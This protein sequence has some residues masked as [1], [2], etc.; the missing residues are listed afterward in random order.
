MEHVDIQPGEI[1][2]PH[3]WEFADATEREAAVITDATLIGRFALQLSP[4]TLWRLAGVSPASWDPLQADPTSSAD[5]SG[6][7]DKTG[8]DHVAGVMTMDLS[9]NETTRTVTITPTGASFDVYIAGV[10]HTKTGPQ[11]IQHGAEYGKHFVF[12]DE[13]GTLVTRQTAWDLRAH[14]PVFVAFWDDSSSDALPFYELH[15]SDRG[16]EWHVNAHNTIGTLASRTGFTASGYTLNDGST[17]AAVTLSIGSGKLRDEDIEVITETLAD[18]GPYLILERS[19]ASGLWRTSHSSVLPFL[20]T[21]NTL[22]YNQLNGGVWGRGAVTEDYYVN[23]FAVGLTCLP[24]DKITPAHPGSLQFAFFPGQ[25]EYSTQEAAFAESFSALSWGDMPIE[26][27]APLYQITIRRNATAPTAYTNTARCAYMRVQKLAGSL[28]QQSSGS[29][30][31]AITATDVSFAPA[32][33]IAASNVQA[34]L[35]ELDTEKISG[36]RSV[37]LKTSDQAFTSTN[38]ADVSQM[39]FAVAANSTY[40]FRFL[41]AYSTSDAAVGISFAINGPANQSKIT[42]QRFFSR[43]A[44]DSPIYYASTYDHTANTSFAA[45]TGLYQCIIEGLI[46]TGNTAGTLALRAASETNGTAVNCLSGSLGYMEK[47]A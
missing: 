25:Q 13:T 9:Y 32:G 26:E 35:V 34:A 18:G 36:T 2:P 47:L 16:L 27:G 11:S 39:S 15:K 45:T 12:Y 14:A 43:S 38:Y 17:D 24:A 23:V 4:H 33:G 19:G 31:A 21:G 29:G 40:H 37:T 5:L 20:Y 46:V 28:A 3:N 30:T 22:Q 10:K 1:H 8:M 6:K 41:A 44:T 7:I 42:Y